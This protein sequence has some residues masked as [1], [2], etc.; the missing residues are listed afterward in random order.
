MKKKSITWLKPLKGEADG[1][2][3]PAGVGK[4]GGKRKGWRKHGEDT[5][6]L[7]LALPVSLDAQLRSLGG[8]PQ[9]HIIEALKPYLK[10]KCG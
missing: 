5:K 3:K 4:S 8:F 6:S 1:R 10:E 2:G 9:E 7:Y